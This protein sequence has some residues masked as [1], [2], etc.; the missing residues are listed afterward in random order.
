[1]AKVNITV[2]T[3]LDTLEVSVDGKTLENV[4]WASVMM[5]PEYDSETQSYENCPCVEI[6][7]RER[8]NG[9]STT[10][11]ICCSEDD[12]KLKI[13]AGNAFTDQLSKVLLKK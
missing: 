13:K 9:V 1:M 3:E 10:T 12:K 5:C 8:S 6:V 2:D 11:R 7:T 4:D